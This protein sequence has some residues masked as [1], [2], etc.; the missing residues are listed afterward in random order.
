MAI[1]VVNDKTSPEHEVEKIFQIG[2]AVQKLWPNF[3]LYVN[4]AQ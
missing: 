3:N 4:V 2:Q 1:N